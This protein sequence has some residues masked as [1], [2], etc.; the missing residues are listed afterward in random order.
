[1]P[2][3]HF[4][5]P[6]SAQYITS[7][8]YAILYHALFRKKTDHILKNILGSKWDKVQLFWEGHKNMR[9]G[10]YGSDV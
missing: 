9:N 6:I 5:G 7:Y 4:Q 1:M 2:F 8:L 3:Y 10:P